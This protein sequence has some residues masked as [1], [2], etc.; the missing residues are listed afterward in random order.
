MLGLKKVGRFMSHAAL[1]G[2]VAS[3]I[4]FL[5][6]L[7]PV[8]NHWYQLAIVQSGSMEPWLPVGSL[9]VYQAQASYQPGEVIAYRDDQ[10][11]VERM[12]IHRVVQKQT[13]GQQVVYLT[14]GD[15]VQFFPPQPV[16][17]SQVEGKVVNHLPQAGYVLSWFQSPVGIATIIFVPLAV[18]IISELTKLP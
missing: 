15:A 14:Q 13:R 9:A 3:A 6:P 4:L 18:L 10:A 17:A 5:I 8:T 11:G 16:F 2:S 1:L 12:I 7:I